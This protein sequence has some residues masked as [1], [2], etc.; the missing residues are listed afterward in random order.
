[1][2]NILTTKNAQCFLFGLLLLIHTI[3][4]HAKAGESPITAD[5]IVGHVTT[6]A[7]VYEWYIQRYDVKTYIKG[8]METP[9]KNILLQYAPNIFTFDKKGRQSIVEALVD[10]HYEAPNRYIQN[11]TA[12]TGTRT[13]PDYIYEHVLQFL[14]INIYNALS[15]NDEILMPFVPGSSDYYLYDYD[16][17]LDTLNV[18]LHKIRIEPKYE[19]PKVISGVVYV[20]DGYWSIS[21][22]KAKGKISFANFELD[23]E[24]G[25]S[26]EDFL[27]PKKMDL[28]LEINILGNHLINRYTS[29]HEYE[30]IVKY[31]NQAVLPKQP[32]DLSA[33]FSVHTDTVPIIKDSLFWIKNRP[34][35]LTPEDIAIYQ[36]GKD[37]QESPFLKKDSWQ[38]TRLLTNPRRFRYRETNFRYSGFLNPL[39]LGY[40]ATNG[41]SYTQQLNL[42]H[43]MK[44]GRSL[45]FYPDIGYVFKSK[46]FFF[47]LP[48]RW[49][50]APK[51]FGAF[52]LSIGNG[53]QGL[54]IRDIEKVNEHLKDSTFKFEDFNLSYYKH[55]RAEVSNRIELSNGLLC[56]LAVTYH[57]RQSVVTNSLP[58][59]ITEELELETYRSFVPHIALIWTPEQYYRMNKQQKIYVKSAWPTFS[60]K[61]ARG[62]KNV[63]RSD[64]DFERYEIDI[65]Q[66]I[67][68]KKLISVQYY[69]GAGIF[70]NTR[71]INFVEFNNFTERNF[72]ESWDDKIGGGFHL[73]DDYW[74]FA[75]NTYWQAHVMYESPF[76]LLSKIKKMSKYVISERLYASQL[77]LPKILPSYTELGYGIGNILFN[78][79]VFVNMERLEFKRIGLKFAFEI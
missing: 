34:I 28:L 55:Y 75:S 72:P 4:S 30:S 14:N 37:A 42:E 56:D 70:S 16:G 7:K 54:N 18:R 31:E 38:F 44:N 50:Y 60:V 76:I 9:K 41:L 6:M 29:I 23:M 33:Y 57:H 63:M 22:L 27:L 64:S 52:A 11:I 66:R 53:N 12:I 15:F 8:T 46:E 35:A 43:S 21:Y 58:P 48:L 19:S 67:P 3:L 47:S 68:L 78:V 79:G 1:M 45:G 20:L 77:Y 26:A 61:Y 5:S 17:T 59:D 65:Q 62:V 10:V 74:Y 13:N 69:A 36:Q 39:K 24:M 25:I 32:Y 73:L 49:S 40:S 2:L 51:R 71:S